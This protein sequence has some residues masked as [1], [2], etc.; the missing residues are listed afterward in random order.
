MGWL[1]IWIGLDCRAKETGS[2][3]TVSVHVGDR[4]FNLHK[5]RRDCVKIN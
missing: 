4:S 1:L 3:A 2:P 5:V